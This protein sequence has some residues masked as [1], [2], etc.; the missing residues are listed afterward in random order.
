MWVDVFPKSIG[1]PGPPFVITPRKPKRWVLCG[2][3]VPQR[4]VT[5]DARV[6]VY[7]VW[8]LRYFLRAVI[9]NTTDVT[10]DETSITGEQMSD[11][12]V[13]GYGW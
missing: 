4:G 5:W 13:K 1:I 9:W 7:H 6:N 10:L 8:M 3:S 11:I 12:Y 2:S